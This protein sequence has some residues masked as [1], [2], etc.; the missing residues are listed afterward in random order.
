LYKKAKLFLAEQDSAHPTK[1]E[2]VY[3]SR[4][5]KK[6]PG[7]PLSARAYVTFLNKLR[8]DV[9]DATYESL[10]RKGVGLTEEELLD[11]GDFINNATGRADLGRFNSEGISTL[12]F[13]PRWV[14]S[15][16]NLLMY[17]LKAAGV[18]AGKSN[19][20]ISGRLRAKIAWEYFNFIAGFSILW[21]LTALLFGDDDDE[22]PLIQWDPRSTDFGKVRTG[23]TR[24]DVTSGL[25]NAIVFASRMATQTAMNQR[26]EIKDLRIVDEG[27]NID[28]GQSTAWDVI[29]RFIRSK[30]AP[31][32]STVTNLVEG[33]NV[34]GE[35]YKEGAAF[36]RDNMGIPA[37]IA[38]NPF[39]Q[40]L[41]G[42]GVPLSVADFYDAAI[43]HGVPKA[44]ALQIL[45]TLGVSMNTYSIEEK[46][47]ES[48][49]P[50]RVSRP[51][52]PERPERP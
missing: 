9:F 32:P 3:M 44:A 43:A 7:V 42:Y 35:S 50:Q 14:M 48:G 27:G 37:E 51:K 29:A 16:F 12:F 40:E 25:S 18:V 45:A 20:A 24:L 36:M 6:V 46:K 1:M 33:Q 15:R 23:D 17:P 5:Q 21:G 39:L 31:I 34:V 52:R 22:H 10:T 47:K 4:W 19:K 30:L 38:E 28:F 41:V 26:G 49:R 8:A 11:L 13:A 2:E